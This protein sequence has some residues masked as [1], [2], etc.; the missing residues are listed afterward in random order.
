MLYETCVSAFHILFS[1]FK[2]FKCVYVCL[3]AAVMCAINMH[4]IKGNLL[5]YFNLLLT[6]AIYS[7]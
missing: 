2:V 5:T 4:L 7:L 3:S 1:F 6:V